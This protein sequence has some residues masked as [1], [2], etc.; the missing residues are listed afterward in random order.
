MTLLGSAEERGEPWRAP[1][2]TDVD[3]AL[4][5]DADDGRSDAGKSVG[6]AMGRNKLIYALSSI[7]VVISADDGKGGTWEGAREA[8]RLNLPVAV[9]VGDG[10]GK[11][12][13]ALVDQGA[14]PVDSVDS[15]F[16]APQPPTRDQL[17]LTFGAST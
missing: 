11:G 3:D 9:W 7:T 16:A 8:L 10:A 17:E 14:T 2:T 12:N 5:R 15:V 1:K 4:F 13:R 6:S